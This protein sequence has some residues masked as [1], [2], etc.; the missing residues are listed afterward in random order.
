[1]CFLS[2]FILFYLVNKIIL[3]TTTA[4]FEPTREFHNRFQVCLLNHSDKLP[5]NSY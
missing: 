4:G 2:M 3:L 1:M 5:P